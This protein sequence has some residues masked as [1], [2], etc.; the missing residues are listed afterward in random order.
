MN[1]V[2]PSLREVVPTIKFKSSKSAEKAPVA[3]GVHRETIAMQKEDNKPWETI[4]E[5]MKSSNEHEFSIQGDEYYVPAIGAM[6]L[7]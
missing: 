2:P 3:D 1:R 5:S 4:Y 7:W 6:M